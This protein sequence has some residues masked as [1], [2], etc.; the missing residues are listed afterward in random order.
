MIASASAAKF[1]NTV[2]KPKVRQMDDTMTMAPD[3]IS[4]LF[5]QGVR[6][7]ALAFTVSVL[8]CRC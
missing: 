6:E 1:A 7:F 5:E 2:I 3:V 8:H 4:G